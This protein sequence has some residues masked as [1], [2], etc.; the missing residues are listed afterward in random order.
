MISE[1]ERRR[2]KKKNGQTY[3]I[4]FRSMTLKIAGR[5]L[6]HRITVSQVCCSEI[7]LKRPCQILGHSPAL[8]IT[9]RKLIDRENKLALCGTSGQTGAKSFLFHFCCIVSCDAEV[10]CRFDLVN[11]AA[12]SMSVFKEM[13]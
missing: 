2:E 11:R 8:P 10:F 5:N 3:L 9:I 6:V 7:V 1:L 4:F 12:P 13:R